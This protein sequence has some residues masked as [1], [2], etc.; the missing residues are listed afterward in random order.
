M[1]QK[2]VREVHENEEGHYPPAIAASVAGLGAIAL[3]IGAA[4]DTGWLAIVGGIVAGVGFVVYDAAR[5]TT[6]DKEF[7][8]RLD[9]LD[10]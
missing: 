7:Y 4:M 5:H 2:V 6:L 8:G 9:K 3:G 1:L 10:K